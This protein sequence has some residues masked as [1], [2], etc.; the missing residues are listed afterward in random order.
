MV[1]KNGWVYSQMDQFGKCKREL[2]CWNGW[3][4]NTKLHCQY[5][6]LIHYYT[7]ILTRVLA[8]PK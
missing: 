1:A 8:L 7:Q 4:M 2:H 6:V 3:K 5:E